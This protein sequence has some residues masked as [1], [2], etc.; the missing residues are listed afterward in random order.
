MR[1]TIRNLLIATTIASVP[2]AIYGKLEYERMSAERIASLL[3]LELEA[4]RN[5]LETGLIC[6]DQLVVDYL[7]MANP[8]ESE[9][10]G[11]YSE[12]QNGFRGGLG[13]GVTIVSKDGRL[14]RAYSWSAFHLLQ[15]VTFAADK[16]ESNFNRT[17]KYS[18]EGKILQE[19]QTKSMAN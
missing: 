17:L 12:F 19:H 16:E 8:C 1:I 18:M 13:H 5:K 14:T 15:P 7:A 4:T 11:R 2:I 6:E 9:D 10:Y 3:R